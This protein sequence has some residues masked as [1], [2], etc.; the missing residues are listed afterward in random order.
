M[1]KE[2]YS[3]GQLHSSRVITDWVRS[4]SLKD[5]GQK[6]VPYNSMTCD[7]PEKNDV[8]A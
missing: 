3:P 4:F 8:L 6:I 7:D 1:M 2:E 5:W